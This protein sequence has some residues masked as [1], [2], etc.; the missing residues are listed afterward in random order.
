MSRTRLTPELVELRA[1]VEAATLADIE[2]VGPEK[3]IAGRG[4]AELARRFAG[5][6][7]PRVR[8]TGGSTRCS[9]AA[10]RGSTTA[11]PTMPSPVSRSR[12]RWRSRSALSPV[13][14]A[15]WR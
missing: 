13:L 12:L 15:R 4:R 5:G 8:S 2:R 1:D 10:A 11:A 9:K 6:G 3:F 7:V 14:T